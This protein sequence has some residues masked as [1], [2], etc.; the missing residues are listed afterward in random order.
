MIQTISLA[1]RNSWN[2]PENFSFIPFFTNVIGSEKN[3]IQTSR[4]VSGSDFET[5]ENKILTHPM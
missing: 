2:F 4:N 3:T 5:P 1:Q